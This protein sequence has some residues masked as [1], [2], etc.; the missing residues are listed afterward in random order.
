MFG[1]RKIQ[2]TSEYQVLRQRLIA[3][4][5]SVNLTA[6]RFAYVRTPEHKPYEAEVIAADAVSAVNEGNLKKALTLATRILENDYTNGGAHVVAAICH[7]EFENFRQADFHRAV[8]IGLFDS[9]CQSGDGKS[10]NTA[11]KV[12]NT[13]EEYFFIDVSDL[14]LRGQRLIYHNGNYFD[15]LEALDPESDIKI[16]V[17]FDISLFYGK[18]RREAN[19]G[20]LGSQ[21]RNRRFGI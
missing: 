17:Y 2:P 19:L 5:L 21:F 8:W 16:E 3:G 9:I 15:V 11:L 18:F 12:I 20:C 14:A 13:E 1:K 4:D 7:R 10:P 6:L